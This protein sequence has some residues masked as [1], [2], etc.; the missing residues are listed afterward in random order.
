M[1]CHRTGNAPKLGTNLCVDSSGVAGHLGHGDCLGKCGLTWRVADGDEDMVTDAAKFTAYP[2]PFSGQT[3]IQF[4]AAE[5]GR[6][7][8]ELNNIDGKL[9]AKLFDGDIKAGQDYKVTLDGSQLPVGIYIATMRSGDTVTHQKLIV[10]G[11]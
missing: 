11:Q 10:S 5:D 2:N 9:I 1:V 4:N 7:T 8:I 6:A 3:M